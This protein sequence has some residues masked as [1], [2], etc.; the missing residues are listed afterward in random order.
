MHVEIR[1]C[2]DSSIG[3]GFLESLDS[4][5]LQMLRNLVNLIPVAGGN[6]GSGLVL[7]VGSLS[8]LESTSRPKEFV[9]W[10]RCADNPLRGLLARNLQCRFPD[11]DYTSCCIATAVYSLFPVK[12]VHFEA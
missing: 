9:H 2:D 7:G 1:G 12:D 6:A 8:C 11:I 3:C 10:L 5:T 4:V